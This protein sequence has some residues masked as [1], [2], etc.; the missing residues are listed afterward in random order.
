MEDEVK[1]AQYTVEHVDNSLRRNNLRLRGLKVG[2]K[3][4][5]LQEFLEN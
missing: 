3:G 2:A 1:E 4:R 5:K